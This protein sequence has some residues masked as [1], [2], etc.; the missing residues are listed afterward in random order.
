M[1]AI[2]WPLRIIVIITIIVSFV[3]CLELEERMEREAISS[4][5]WFLVGKE[6]FKS[7]NGKLFSCRL[8]RTHP[9]YDDV[10]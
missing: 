6:K 5:V 7:N 9:L 3:V 8:F 10:G 4:F 1:H 2:L